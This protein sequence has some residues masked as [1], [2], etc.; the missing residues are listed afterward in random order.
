MGNEIIIKPVG[1][2]RSPAQE[3]VDENWGNV[4]SEIYLD[5]EFKD[6][7][8]GLAAFSHVIVIFYLHKSS[9]DV[10]RDLIRR[11]QGRADMPMT[12]IFAQRA[13]HRPNPLGVTAARI[14]EIKEGVLVVQGLDAIDGTPVIDLK[15][16][17]PDYDL[18]D[19]ARVPDWVNALMVNYF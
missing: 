5:P 1:I 15:P 6:G 18:R 9:F 7:L 4:V 12:G 3:D 16:Y 2:V 14:L 19:D 11:P 10:A 8:N 13:K 17:Y